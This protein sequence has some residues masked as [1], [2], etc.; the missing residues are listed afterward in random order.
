MIDLSGLRVIELG[1]GVSAAWATKW[2][3]DLGA[4]VI[5]VESPGGDLLRQRGPYPSSEANADPDQAGFFHYLNANKRSVVLDL[6]DSDDREE[7]LALIGTAEA[8]VHNLPLQRLE[9][10][11]LRWEDLHVLFPGLIV[12]G[13]TPFGLTG[14]RRHWRG[15]EI[16]V[17]NAG[18]WTYLSPG[19]STETDRPPLKA[20]G[21]QADFQTG[22][23]GAIAT[24]AAIYRTRQTGQGE[25]IDVAGQAVV[26]CM[27]EA[28]LPRFTYSREVADRFGRKGLNP[29][30]LY[31]CQDGLI[32][33]MVAEEDQWERLVDLMGRP[34]WAE[35]EIFAKMSDRFLNADALDIFMDEWV[36]GWKVDEL[37]HEAQK[38]RICMA[39]VLETSDL[40]DNEHLKARGFLAQQ[41]VA[42]QTLTVPGPPYQLSGG[43]WG[44]RREAPK[45]GEHQDEV[46]AECQSR[47]P[48]VRGSAKTH[49]DSPVRP[50]EGIRVLD[51]S[52]VW[53]GPY[54]TLQLAHLGADVVKVES[55]SRSDLGRRLPIYAADAPRDLNSS[56]YFNQW[57]QGKRSLALDLAHEEAIDLLKRLIE[58]CDVLTENFASG[59]MDR[60]G[61]GWEV[62]RKI[63]PRLIMASISGYGHTGPW[64]SYSA[65][66]PATPPISG[67]SAVSGYRGGEP[68][69]VGLALGDPAAGL[70]AAA[71]ICAALVSREKT[72]QGQHIEISLWEATSVLT[73]E[74]WLHHA[75]R[76]ESLPR[77]GNRDILMA[78]HGC[79]ATQEENSWISIACANDSEWQA[80]CSVFS[81]D[82]AEDPRFLTAEK[83][84]AHEDELD[85]LLSEWVAT[86]S[87]WPLTE[88]LQAAGVAAFPSVTTEELVQDPHLIARGFFEEIEH[89]TVGARVHAGIPWRLS[90]ADNGVK[91]HAPLLGIHTDEVLMER[92]GVS[93]DQI[94]RWREAGLLS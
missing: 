57:G 79:Y 61:L 83:R 27:L 39:P 85:R 2:M 50:L 74:A 42:G 78:P 30:G 19:T 64:A 82:L 77:M 69:E 31:A 38:R 52:W 10:A 16:T 11:R 63:N 25:H 92:L 88:K 70:T 80:L 29:W 8:V 72:G 91:S 36:A 54:C 60:L 14:P 65:Y 84:K 45:L 73:G 32:F 15:E 13:L 17:A 7:L 48:A 94:A 51:L 75:L 24:L 9:A 93:S 68:Q 76:N 20:S 4:D 44:L 18:G 3:A 33:L 41:N 21:H 34:E 59:V 22:V 5:K 55:E 89:P 71:G 37:F 23:T 66:G 26:G 12:C 47:P 28:S 1:S 81:P 56:G 49:A 67:L 46:K 43:G 53:A 90:E 40:V 62:L 58:N 35:L 87:R 6:D 86:E